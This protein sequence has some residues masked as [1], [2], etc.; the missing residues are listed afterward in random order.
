MFVDLSPLNFTD[1]HNNL[2][3]IFLFVLVWSSPLLHQGGVRRILPGRAGGWTVPYGRP[4]LV[5]KS[6]IELN[7][8]YK[9][10][11]SI[12]FPQPF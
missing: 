10:C 8:G 2:L 4:I 3:K 9:I 7:N 6:K 12:L 5:A 11:Q 1:Y